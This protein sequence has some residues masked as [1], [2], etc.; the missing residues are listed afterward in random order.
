MP[1]LVKPVTFLVLVAMST[2][3]G[4]PAAAQA[5]ADSSRASRVDA[6]FARWHSPD[7]PGASVV[8]IH[9]GKVVLR[10]GYGM[11]S[12][13]QGVPNRPHTVFDIAS[14]SKQF[15]AFAIALLEA[16]G[17]LAFTDDVR[18]YVPE[19]PDFGQVITI[20]HLLHHTSGLRD[21]PGTLRMGGWR[22]D[23][24]IS[25]D[26]I[27]R[28]AF[29]QQRLNFTPGDDYA[30][31]NTGYN[32]LAEVVQRVSKQSFREF[33]SER[34]FRPLGMTST[35]F[36]DDHREVVRNLADS[37]APDRDGNRGYL[38]VTSNLTALASSSLFTTV[39]DLA[40]W[41]GN[42][43]TAEVGGR[44][45]IEGS[46]RRGILNSG[47][48]IPY[49]LGQSVGSYRGARTVSHGGSWAGYRST[50]TRFPDQRF[51]VM[52]LAN[53]ADM[54]PGRLGY[55]I[56]DLYLGDRLGEVVAADRPEPQSPPA[57]SWTPTA[58]ELGGYTGE[59]RSDELDTSWHL[60]L[61]GGRLVASHFRIGD[62]PVAPVAKDRFNAPALGGELTFQSDQR[63]RITGF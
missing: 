23:D 46:H 1:S 38:R 19:L 52:I 5:G 55:Q 6:L 53:T 35:H 40:K 62:T 50:L 63:G 24:V 31:S 21:W 51:A 56:A 29:A 41:V 37:Y 49:A 17:K 59:Y 14:V 58:A 12:L 3:V 48:T 7:S 9:D 22:Y 27:L 32:V 60:R 4:R 18:T 34:I 61:V 13:E 25:F 36:H 43:E 54:N 42:F 11:A 8:V 2:L 47:D 28:M 44:A 45:V 30:Y 20:D 26:Q 15:G 57:A 16:D 10:K 33:T 39:E